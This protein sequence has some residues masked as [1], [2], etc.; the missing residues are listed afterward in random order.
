MP[1]G[2]D[3]FVKADLASAIPEIWGQRMNEFY[4]RKLKLANIFL[5]RS[6]DV[7][8][9]GDTIH[10]P[11]TTPFVANTKAPQTQVTLQDPALN[12]V[13]L[14]IDQ[15]L[16]ASFVI[17]DKDAAQVARQYMLQEVEAKGAAHAIGKAVDDAIAT[18]LATIS[19]NTVTNGSGGAFDSETYLFD[20]IATLAENDVD[21]DDRDNLCFIFSPD[22]FLRE[23]QLLDR[24]V[25]T[26]YSPSANGIGNLA[27]YRVLDIPVVMSNAVN[28]TEG[29]LVSKDTIHWATSPLGM[30]SEGGMVGSDG[31]R[32][33]S[34]YV[35]EWLGTLTTADTLFGVGVNRQDGAVKF[36]AG[37]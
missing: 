4:R 11:G 17:E 35:A 32:V 16:E 20:A 3:H 28:G 22:K 8:A 34:N 7:R 15:H 19:T 30:M 10:I 24:F 29:Y 13:D 26:D 25:S 6:E 33:Q 12:N 5:D 14:V 27:T 31:I 36:T 37:A 21:V 1:L 2:T 9:G 18:A 23:I